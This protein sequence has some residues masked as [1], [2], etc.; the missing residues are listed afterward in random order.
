MRKFITALIMICVILVTILIQVNLLNVVPL[1]G[2]IANIGIVLVAGI[3]LMSGE[4][5]GGMTGAFYGLLI[6]VIFGKLIGINI[7]L[8]TLTG[9]F[10]GHISNGFSKDN[11]TAMMVIVSI[12]T[13]LFEMSNV[14]LL[15]IFTKT[16]FDMVSVLITVVL[17]TAY[18]MMLTLMLHKFIVEL[19][20]VI[21]K[22]KNSYYLL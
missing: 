1:F 13:I 9:I 17:E 20:E 14:L 16:S 3:G 12:T 7:L 18:N 4:F 22:S 6:D 15:Y 19:G 11:K 8:Y 21:N 10:T 2:V 5:V